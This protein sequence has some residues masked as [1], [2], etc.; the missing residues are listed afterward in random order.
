[1]ITRSTK[2]ERHI[3]NNGEV[4][5]VDIQEIG[6]FVMKTSNQRCL[7]P[8]IWSLNIFQQK[9][10]TPKSCY[11]EQLS[12]GFKGWVNISRI[13]SNAIKRNLILNNY[14]TTIEKNSLKSFQLSNID[15]SSKMFTTGMPVI[16]YW[17][18]YTSSCVVC[19]DFP[20]GIENLYWK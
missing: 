6:F 20:Y 15:I 3:S 16:Q 18:Y 19:F 13:S 17:A 1:M 4:W 11:F 10:Q 5:N 8:F 2:I 9:T 14:V 7:F 12:R